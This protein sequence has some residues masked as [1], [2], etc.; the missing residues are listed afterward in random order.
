MTRK[1]ELIKKIKIVIEPS[2][3]SAAAAATTS[4]NNAAY[5]YD[6]LFPALPESSTPRFPSAAPATNSI[7]R[8]QNTVVTQVILENNFK[9]N[10]NKSLNYYQFLF[11]S[12][13]LHHRNA[14]MRMTSLVRVNLYVHVSKS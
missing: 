7:K 12:F 10:T 3:S 2:T 8:I 5:S 4:N 13:M 9:I 14:S 11:R 6:D 1:F